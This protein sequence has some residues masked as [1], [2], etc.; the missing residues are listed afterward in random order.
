MKDIR[1]RVLQEWNAFEDQQGRQPVEIHL[2]TAE[3]AE[4]LKILPMV[5]GQ[6]AQAAF[7]EG[8]KKTLPKI[9][10]FKAVYRSKEFKLQ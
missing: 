8:I 10:G 3:E 9:F 7:V 5:S 4:I 6:L 2:T 1:E